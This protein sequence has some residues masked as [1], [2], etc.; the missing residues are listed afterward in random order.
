R[1]TSGIRSVRYKLISEIK[2]MQSYPKNDTEE[3][4]EWFEEH[5]PSCQENHKGSSGAMEVGAIME[6][7]SRSE[8][9]LVSNMKTT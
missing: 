4:R 6:M 5:E 7:L 2:N 9:L 8:E 1:Y 3:Y